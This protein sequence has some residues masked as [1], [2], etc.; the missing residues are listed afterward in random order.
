MSSASF[1]GLS[2]LENPRI[3][4]KTKTVVFDLQAA[5]SSSGS[6]LIGSIRYFNGDS[7]SPTSAVAQTL[8]TAEVYSQALSPMDYHIIGDTVW[9]SG[10]FSLGQPVF[11]QVCGLASNLNKEDATFEI[12]LFH[13]KIRCVSNDKVEGDRGYSVP[14]RD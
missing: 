4:P 3:I 10:E 2:V 12:G 1:T 9:F 7:S 8:P 11:V 5:L 13:E 6:A 14:R